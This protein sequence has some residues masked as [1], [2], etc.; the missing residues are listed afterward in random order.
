MF[1]YGEISSGICAAAA[2]RRRRRRSKL[3]NP[4]RGHKSS[5]LDGEKACLK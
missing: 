4:D 3:P 1:R 2:A 5:I